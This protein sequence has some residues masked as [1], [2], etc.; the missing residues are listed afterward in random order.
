MI[1]CWRT[2]PEGPPNRA[3]YGGQGLWLIG[4]RFGTL[5]KVLDWDSTG[6]GITFTVN[7]GTSA[8]HMKT[9]SGDGGHASCASNTLLNWA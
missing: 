1:T 7:S 5:N 6:A 2:P 8:L 9:Q 4:T 3:P